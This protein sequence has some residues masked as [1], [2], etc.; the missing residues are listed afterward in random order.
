MTKNDPTCATV[1]PS[2]ADPETHLI[3]EREAAARLGLAVSTLRRWRWA[4]SRPRS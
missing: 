1:S 3:T 2:R 4:A